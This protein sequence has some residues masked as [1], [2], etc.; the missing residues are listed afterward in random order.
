MR[1]PLYLAHRGDW[2]FAPENTIAAM[3]AALAVPG[4]DGLEF[5]V[6]SARDGVPVLLH[7]DTLDRVHGI[8]ASVDSLTASELAEIGVPTLAEVLAA[9][10]REPFLDIEL[11]GQATSSV[12]DVVQAG[13]G[14]PGGELGRAVVSSF[15]ID[16]L[17]TLQEQRPG[18]PRWLNVEVL[19][20]AVIEV[21]R[22]L[23]CVG[24]SA[25]W[26]SIDERRARAVRDAGLDL[27][28]WTVRRRSTAQRLGRL[29]VVAICVEAAALDG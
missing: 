20:P 4:C 6:Q 14:E 3:R 16:T 10:G 27:A 5:D 23:G 13:R 8:R 17:A 25:G 19:G 12:I 15:R 7:D 18:W 9:V 26:H 24:I 29:G 21:A 1:R 2:R 28:A 22:L 11:K